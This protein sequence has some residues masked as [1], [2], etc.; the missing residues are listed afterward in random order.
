MESENVIDSLAYNTFAAENL[1]ITI[2][3]L[4][5]SHYATSFEVL[6]GLNQVAEAGSSD[7]CASKV[8]VLDKLELT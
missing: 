8:Q 1:I 5:T 6:A 4:F 3:Q 2:V 7:V